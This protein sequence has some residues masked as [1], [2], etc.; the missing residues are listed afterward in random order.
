[1][2]MIKDCYDPAR[3]CASRSY[4]IG[5]GVPLC[6]IYINI[7]VSYFRGEVCRYKFEV[8]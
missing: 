4:V 8:N 5:A 1:M 6:N 7:H 3:T 2:N